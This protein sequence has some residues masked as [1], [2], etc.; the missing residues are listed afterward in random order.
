MDDIIKIIVPVETS[1]VIKA[2]RNTYKEDI[3]I[4]HLKKSESRTK[5]QGYCVKELDEDYR[6][7]CLKCSY[8]P[9]SLILKD[10][11]VDIVGQNYLSFKYLAEGIE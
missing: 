11:T 7:K 8:Y 10:K 6:K 5:M 3:N 9:F 1:D 2:Q 4:L